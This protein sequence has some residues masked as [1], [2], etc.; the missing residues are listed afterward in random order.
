MILNYAIRII[1]LVI[2]TYS[3][4]FVRKYKLEKWVRIAVNAAEQMADA[5]IITVPKK[6][7]V[8]DF[9][10]DKFKF[11]VSEAELDTLIEA[12][13]KELNLLQKNQN[14][15]IESYSVNK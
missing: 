8:I 13:V 6:Q 9:I 12:M 3:I 1:V 15:N 14:I 7:Y 10:N 11:A 4:D 2:G 5:G